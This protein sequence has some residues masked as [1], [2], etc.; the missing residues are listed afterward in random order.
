MFEA[1]GF[2]VEPVHPVAGKMRFPGA[3]CKFSATPAQAP[4]PAPLLG[5]HNSDVYC[6]MLGYSPEKL[7]KMKQA[8]T[9]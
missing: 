9:I 8:G 2:M 1:R 6:R 7:N 4:R 5:E 3:P